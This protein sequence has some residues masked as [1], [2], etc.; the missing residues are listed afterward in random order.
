MYVVVRILKIQ[1]G[2]QEKMVERFLSKSVMTNS[3]GFIKAELLF[4]KKNPEFDLYRHM[5]YWKDK[6]AFFVWEGSPEHIALHRDKNSGHHQK[7]EEVI[8]VTRETY[9]LIASK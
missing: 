5:I 6:K 1:K 3:P 4:D 8:E 7:P 9:E 2:F